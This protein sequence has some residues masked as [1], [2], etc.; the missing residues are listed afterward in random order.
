MNVNTD[1]LTPEQID[2]FNR[3]KLENFKKA[4]RNM[5]ATTQA[6]YVKSDDKSYRERHQTYTR[7]EIERVVRTGTSIERAALSEYFFATNGLY[8]RIILHY[9][10]FLTYSWILVP[11]PKDKLGKGNIAEKKTAAT[12][13]DASDFCTTFQIDRKCT[14]FAKEVLVKGAY[15]GLIHD[16]GQNVVIQ[17]LPFDYCR[18]RFKNAQDVDIVELNLAFF[19]TIR[20]EGLRNEILKTYPAIIY[21]AYRKYKFH[22]GPKWMFL[23]AEMGI[24][25]SYFEERPFFL[26]L[27]PLLDDLDDYKQID[28]DRNM[29]ALRKIL[30]QQVL[31]DGMKL[32]FEPQEA[33]QMHE[34]TLEMLANNPDVDVLTTYNK[35]ELLDMSSD[36]DE[37][38]E[39]EDVQNLIYSSAGLSK[40]L[41]FSTTEAGLNYSISNDLAMMMILGQRFA[42][43][44]TALLNYK[45]E[46]KKV[47]FKLLILPISYYNS[48]DYTSRARELASFGYSFLTPILSTGLD[49]TNL[50][51]LKD[52][53]ND[54]LDLDEVLKP[55]QSSYT[56]SGKAQGEPIGKTTQTGQNTEKKETGEKKETEEKKETT[57]KKETEKKDDKKTTEKK[58]S[59]SE[60]SSKKKDDK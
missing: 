24:Y 37:K 56:Q 30:V 18:S 15:Y 26:D 14:L 58:D 17:D 20:D 8:K 49:Q 31:T 48:A 6:A 13:Y 43:F 25:F 52:L 11:Y 4:F 41:F 60:S 54:L 42:H 39:I 27:I 36:D 32:V 1:G 35:V 5:V 10:T 3:Q 23:P 9:A 44:F 33:E 22:N 45:F 19:D 38:T 55:L 53:E 34:G 2:R 7:E 21:K 16:E 29:Q 47:K 46:N 57:E 50:S 40:E 28:K 12:Y 51:A 59:K